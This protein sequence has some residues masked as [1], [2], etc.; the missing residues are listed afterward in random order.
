[1]IEFHDHTLLG[2]VLGT[3]SEL[4]DYCTL[5]AGI[6]PLSPPSTQSPVSWAHDGSRRGVLAD[7]RS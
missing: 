7:A 6:L 4:Q 3:V 5:G 2:V 1:M